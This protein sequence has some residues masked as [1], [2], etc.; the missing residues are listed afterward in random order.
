MSNQSSTSNDNSRT[1]EDI[2]RE[3][4]KKSAN[5]D[6]I[7]RGENKYYEKISS[8]L[9]RESQ[10]VA[11]I[12]M[13]RIEKQMLYAAQDYDINRLG[14][15]RSQQAYFL[16]SGGYNPLKYTERQFEILAELQHWGGETN[17]IDFTTDYRV[18]LFFACDGF[19][20]EDGR[21]I[22]Q[23]QKT[24]KPITWKPTEPAHRIE[25][26][27]SVFVRPPSGFIQPNPEDVIRIPKNLKVPLLKH[28]V[29]QDP[30]ITHKTIYNDLHG[31]IRRQSRYRNA[32]VTFYIAVDYEKQ[33][34]VAET[35]QARQIN[36]KKAI[37]YYQT[38][39]ELMPNLIMAHIRCGIGY[40]KN[41]ANFD[42]AIACFNEVLDWEPNNEMAYCNRGAAYAGKGNFDR[43][44]QDFTQAIELKP[45]SAETYND[46]GIAYDM[47]GD[48]DRA[49]ED[50]NKAI[51]LKSDSAETY[52]NRGNIY[53]KKGDFDR[54]IQDYTQAIELKPDLSEAY[55]N[56]GSVYSKKGDFDSAIQDYI[57]AIQ[58]NPDDAEIYN[59]RGNAHT[60]KDDFDSAIVDYTKAIELKSDYADAYCNRGAA[61]RNKDEIDN[62]IADY[63]KAIQLQPDLAEAYYNRGAAYASKG[64]FENAIKDLNKAIQLKPDYA[65]VIATWFHN[66]FGSIANF[67]QKTGIQLPVDIA[68]LLTPPQA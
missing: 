50:F 56:R 54:A 16:W 64:D 52:N 38:A 33:G 23:D 46:R 61:Y 53:L 39:I 40:G 29:R 59:N 68:G 60:G 24:I 10:Q 55:S 8:T 30:P 28:L 27:K 67:E 14:Q 19:Y 3:I 41:L 26:Q 58:L 37:N 44:I 51:E 47:K 22:V 42:A 57:Q 66:T 48:V 15:S 34:D 62:A 35:L 17:L 31:F 65:I 45:D 43:A 18:A 2:I 13:D 21:V 1:V 9:Y 63:T 32:F 5:G 12:G 49:I 20:N 4:E 25:A 11:N 36:H 7:Y 6:Y